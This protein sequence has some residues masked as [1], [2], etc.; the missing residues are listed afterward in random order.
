[1]TKE[2]AY[3]LLGNQS[4]V[5]LQ[6]MVKALSFH[7]WQNTVEDKERLEAAKVILR[8]RSSK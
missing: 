5:H 4:R 1:M 8:E 2:L 7:P 3:A 6:M